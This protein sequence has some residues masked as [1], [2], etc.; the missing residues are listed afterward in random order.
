[1]LSS[2]FLA[3]LGRLVGTRFR[4]VFESTT[5]SE[6][7]SPRGASEFSRTAHGRRRSWRRS[8]SS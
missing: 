1:M 8:R 7:A 5:S 3:P 6:R 2:R 4:R